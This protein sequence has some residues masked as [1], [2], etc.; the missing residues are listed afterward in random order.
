ME[1]VYLDTDK[2]Y[3]MRSYKILQMN[4]LGFIVKQKQANHFFS[5]F[6]MKTFIYSLLFFLFSKS[7]ALPNNR[8]ALLPLLI[9]IVTHWRKPHFEGCCNQ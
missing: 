9:R 4:V 1:M 7:K 8:N 2:D 6:Q 5:L 3:V